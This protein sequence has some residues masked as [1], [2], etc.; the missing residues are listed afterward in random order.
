[1][2]NISADTHASFKKAL[3]ERLNN[4]FE[5]NRLSKKGNWEMTLKVTFALAWWIGSYFLLYAA[6]WTYPQFF[7]LYL[8]QG[9]GQIFMFLNIAHDANHNS[10]SNNR[11]INKTLSY[12]LDACGIS[13]YL[14]RVMH[15]KGH[16]AVMN[17]Y[18]EDE[19]IFAH[20]IFRFSP[21][22]PWRKS[23]RFQHI[24]VFFMY[25]ITTLDF[26]FVK[27]FEYLFFKNNKHVEHVKYPLSEWIII[28][29]SKI[30]YLTYMIVLPVLIL[31]FS[32][33]QVV[34]AFLITHF[35]M[36]LIAAWI[37]QVAH[38]LDI[39]EFPHARHDH[40]FVD[41]I[42]ATTTDYATRSRIANFI[43]GGLNHHV[44]HHIFPQ[45]AHTHYPKLT[46]IVRETAAEFGVDYRENVYMYQAM[47]HHVKLL[48][49]LGH[50]PAQMAL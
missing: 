39:N 30:I 22:A 31:G 33:G 38:L 50:P 36:G 26:I 4:Y 44:V 47:A 24:Y 1:M 42:F 41:H 2:T 32:V 16:H 9:L 43:C 27:D 10:I 37:I 7:G 3:F 13:S 18:G 25:A 46:K 11:F 23:H 8:L 15:N 21:D 6:D 35:I 40:D 20:G 14:W 5:V 17:V 48:K 19:G 34:L 12:V 49:L 28:I 45:V 29:G